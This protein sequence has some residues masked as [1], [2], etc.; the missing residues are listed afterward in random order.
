MAEKDDNSMSELSFEEA[1][2]QLEQVVQRLEDGE[3]PLEQA[4][5]LYQEG[6]KL[7]KL[8]HEKLQTVEKKM[9]Q[10]M[11]QNGQLQSLD[12]QEEPSS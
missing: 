1:M 11:D 4:I 10:V 3:V 6:I 5:S 2:T 7:S 9:D 8:C 12:I